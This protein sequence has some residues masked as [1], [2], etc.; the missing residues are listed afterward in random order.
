MMQAVETAAQ[1]IVFSSFV[2]LVQTGVT[3]N[4]VEIYA[5]V[6][7]RSLHVIELKVVPPSDQQLCKQ[8]V[9]LAELVQ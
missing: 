3:K 8:N 7:H 1:E 2:I 5:H 9:C 4:Y 6:G